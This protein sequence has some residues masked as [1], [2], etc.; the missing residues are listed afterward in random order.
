MQ[1]FYAD[2]LLSA[3][4]AHFKDLFI[5]T[6]RRCNS[7]YVEL[8]SHNLFSTVSS[9]SLWLSSDGFVGSCVAFINVTNY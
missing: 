7:L 5:F 1:F 4:I 9:H 3:N 8:I 2:F 6:R